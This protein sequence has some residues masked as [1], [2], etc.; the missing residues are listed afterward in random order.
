MERQVSQFER[1]VSQVSQFER[2][3]GQL[4]ERERGRETSDRSETT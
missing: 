3:A 1:Q 2:Q 4:R